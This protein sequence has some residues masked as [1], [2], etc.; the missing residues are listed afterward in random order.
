MKSIIGYLSSIAFILLYT[1]FWDGKSGITILTVLMVAPV[2]SILLT[3]TAKGSI[4]MSVESSMHTLKKGDTVILTAV[5]KK[6]GI[7]PAPFITATF[8]TPGNLTADVSKSMFALNSGTA[9]RIQQS[10]TAQ[11]WGVAQIGVEEVTMSDYLGLIKFT[12]YKEDGLCSYADTIEVYPDIPQ[13]PAQNALVRTLCDTIA[14]DDNEETRDN[15]IGG[16]GMPGYDH[17]EY[18]PG[19]PVKRIN[20]K[21]SSKRNTLMVRLDEA[22]VGSRLVFVLDCCNNQLDLKDPDQKLSQL[23][24]DEKIIEAA[25][26]VLSIL[27]KQ[28]MESSFYYYIGQLWT[29]ADISNER[30]VLALQYDLAKYKFYPQT[31]RYKL[32]RIGLDKIEEQK[33]VSAITVFTSSYDAV[34]TEQIQKAVCRGIAVNTVVVQRQVEPVGN[35]WIVNDSYEFAGI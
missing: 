23:K 10:Y 25:L 6:S 30:D 20:W 22:V 32:T 11:I 8:F 3:L 31:A 28:G 4:E 27:V 26:A 29:K 5:F 24:K 9:L 21:L 7:L 33:E 17:K 13:A 12:L 15:I 16:S 35:V 14:Y 34:L 2:I 1:F 19:D 18:S